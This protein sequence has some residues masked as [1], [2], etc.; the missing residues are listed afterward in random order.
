[1]FA[2]GRKR[3]GFCDIF[4]GVLFSTFCWHTDC[5]RGLDMLG[6]LLQELDATS[7]AASA[8]H[9]I[10]WPVDCYLYDYVD[11]DDTLYFHI[12][13]VAASMG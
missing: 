5:L 4:L 1:M 2:S 7:G 8:L 10:F 13:A 6:Y 11:S 3:E 12:V 9:N